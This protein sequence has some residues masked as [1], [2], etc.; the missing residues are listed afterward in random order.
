MDPYDEYVK[1]IEIYIHMHKYIHSFIKK[2]RTEVPLQWICEKNR[3]IHTAPKL[4][5]F[6]YRV[7][8]QA[9]AVDLRIGL[10]VKVCLVLG[11]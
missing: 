1:K 5:L 4:C 7:I 10:R 8:A 2:M 11:V 6:S 3:Y 9:C